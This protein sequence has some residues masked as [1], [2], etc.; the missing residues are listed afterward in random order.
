MPQISIAGIFEDGKLIGLKRFFSDGNKKEQQFF[1]LFK[2]ERNQEVYLVMIY[3]ERIAVRMKTVP[4][5]KVMTLYPLNTWMTT[6][7]SCPATSIVFDSVRLQYLL[8]NRQ[9][10][11]HNNISSNF[12]EI[13]VL[14]KAWQP[15]FSTKLVTFPQHLCVF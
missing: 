2:L 1:I 10:D 6:A 12:I 11:L 8:E 4:G 15:E 7:A 14:L 5:D 3:F 13:S 9:K